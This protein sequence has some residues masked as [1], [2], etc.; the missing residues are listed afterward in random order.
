MNE[1]LA[2]KRMLERLHLSG[3]ISGGRTLRFRWSCLPATKAPF[4]YE[5]NGLDIFGKVPDRVQKAKSNVGIINEIVEQ[6]NIERGQRPEKG[7]I[8]LVALNHYWKL[9]RADSQYNGTELKHFID[10]NIIIH[11]RINYISV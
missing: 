5:L 1:L 11:G 2:R 6:T 9:R 3:G 10:S 8:D 4:T 7:V